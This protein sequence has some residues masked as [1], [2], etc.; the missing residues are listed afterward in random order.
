MTPCEEVLSKISGL[1]IIQFQKHFL[2]LKQ[3]KE[4]RIATVLILEL[5]VFVIEE[6]NVMSSTALHHLILNIIILLNMPNELKTVRIT[7][8]ISVNKSLQKHSR[9]AW[10]QR[11]WAA[12]SH[13]FSKA[14]EPKA[15]FFYFTMTGTWQTASIQS[16][17][18]PHQYK[19]ALWLTREYKKGRRPTFS[20]L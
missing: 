4:V 9:A 6:I 7:Y 5:D 2:T 15:M 19:E 13:L 14:W 12:A 1:G 18:R 17:S 8:S 10:I 16:P 3:E 20:F 11:S